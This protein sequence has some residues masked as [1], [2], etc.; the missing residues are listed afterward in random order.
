MG[1]WMANQGRKTSLRLSFNLAANNQKYPATV[2][3]SMA[4][5]RALYKYSIRQSGMRP[6]GSGFQSNISRSSS[7]WLA[8]WAAYRLD[9]DDDE[10]AFN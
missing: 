1:S 3:R 6:D 10:P 2:K 4:D 9:Q 8:R 5:E 7:H